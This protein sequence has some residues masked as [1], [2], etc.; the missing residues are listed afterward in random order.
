MEKEINYN[1]YFKIRLCSDLDY[2]GMV[3]D[4]VY[5]NSSLAT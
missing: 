4:I 2:D 5:K 3:V 1:K